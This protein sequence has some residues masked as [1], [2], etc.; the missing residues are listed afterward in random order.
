[1]LVNFPAFPLIVIVF[2]LNSQKK[3][4]LKQCFK[5][6]KELVVPIDFISFSSHSLD[7]PSSED[8]RLIIHI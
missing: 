5:C 8:R 7:N 6:K 1:M 3:D 2:C 4:I